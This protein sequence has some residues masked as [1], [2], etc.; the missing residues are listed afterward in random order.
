[1]EKASFQRP[2]GWNRQSL[3]F[4]SHF[5]TV[6]FFASTKTKQLFHMTIGWYFSY[7]ATQDQISPIFW[8]VESN[9]WADFLLG[10][11]NILGY[12]FNFWGRTFQPR[13]FFV[14]PFVVSDQFLKERSSTLWKRCESW[15]NTTFLPKVGKLMVLGFETAIVRVPCF[16]PQNP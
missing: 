6:I 10:E 13:P 9:L 14:R 1:M 4:F 15:E 7:L 5:R 12:F 3:F 2:H 8:D 16:Q 11:K